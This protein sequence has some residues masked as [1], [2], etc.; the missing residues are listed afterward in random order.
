MKRILIA[1]IALACSLAASAQMSKIPQRLEIIQI[2]NEGDA[3]FVELFNAPKDGQNHYFLSVGHLGIGDKVVQ[4][5]IDPLTELFVPLGGT[6]EEALA[7]L[8][9]IKD[10]F[11]MLKG[12]AA[13]IE[14]LVSMFYP[15][16]D[17]VT[18]RVVARKFLV[19]KVLEFSIPTG[20]EGLVRAAFVGKSDLG[21]LIVSLK[22][23]RKIHPK[24][25]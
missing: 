11:K 17:T 9:E 22:L 4:V 8:E 12:Q 19:S 3:T 5:Y 7:R 2:E 16:G 10:L 6:V 1:M 18:A 23:Y 20:E 21:G 14:T 25:P 24:E 15:G 13:D